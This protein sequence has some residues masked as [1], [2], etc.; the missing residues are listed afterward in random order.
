MKKRDDEYKIVFTRDECTGK[1]SIITK[2]IVN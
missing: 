1:T 2:Y